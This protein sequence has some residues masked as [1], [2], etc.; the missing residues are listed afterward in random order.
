MEGVA[1]LL[2]A[3]FH[4]IPLICFVKAINDGND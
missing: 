4:P 3:M 1:A 2:V